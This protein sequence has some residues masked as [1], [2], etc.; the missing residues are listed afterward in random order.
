MQRLKVRYVGEPARLFAFRDP[1][2]QQPRTVLVRPGDIVEIAVPDGVTQVPSFE[3]VKPAR[4]PAKEVDAD[5][6][7]AN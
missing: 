3:V 7:Q 5:G 1:E 2:T 6:S 4:K